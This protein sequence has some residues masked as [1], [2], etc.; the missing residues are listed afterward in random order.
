M[1]RIRTT[2][3]AAA[4]AWLAAASALAAPIAY[5]G[6][7]VSFE[8]PSGADHTLAENQDAISASVVVTRGPTQGLFNNALE[9]GYALGSPAGTR[10]AFT[11]NNPGRVVSADNFASLTF[12]N[13]QD[14]VLRNPSNAVGVAGVLH[15]V[16]EDIYLDIRIT[17]W[18]QRV[19]GGFSY[20]RASI[21]EPSLAALL[22]VSAAGAALRRA[23][24]AR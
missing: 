7:S 4:L 3:V 21:P 13:W 10:W 6:L 12:A 20:V 2:L 24:R 9:S 14:A 1:Q 19:G 17:S 18:D 5:T 16:A 22:A 23:R 8:K 15:L 11:L